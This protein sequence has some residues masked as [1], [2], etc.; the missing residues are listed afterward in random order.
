MR[1]VTAFQQIRPAKNAADTKPT[2]KATVVWPIMLA[3]IVA[4]AALTPK[5]VRKVVIAVSPMIYVTYVAVLWPTAQHTRPANAS[6]PL[7]VAGGAG[8]GAGIVLSEDPGGE[9]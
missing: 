7:P 8:A 1:S 3:P 5:P 4:L 6:A 9:R 2:H